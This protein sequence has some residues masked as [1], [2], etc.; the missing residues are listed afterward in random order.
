MGY[1]LW[2]RKES[3][4]AEHTLTLQRETYKT[5]LY[6]D[7]LMKIW[8]KAQENLILYFPLEKWFSIH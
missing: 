8:P 2:G 7:N 5:R 1:S 4:T 3:D 6:I